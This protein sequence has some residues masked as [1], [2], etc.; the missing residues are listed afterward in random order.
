MLDK[1]LERIRNYLF[2]FYDLS[3]T[4]ELNFE[5]KKLLKIKLEKYDVTIRL[6]PKTDNNYLNGNYGI[7]FS[8]SANKKYQSELNWHGGGYLKLYKFDNEEI[9]N[10]LKDFG[11]NKT[12]SQISI[13]DYIKE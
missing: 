13:F 3:S 9:D 1:E 12:K 5:N 8:Y 2:S 4:I 10:F 11:V 6:T 7:S